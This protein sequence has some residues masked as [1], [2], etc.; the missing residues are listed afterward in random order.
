MAELLHGLIPLMKELGIPHDWKI[1]PLD[2]N[3]NLLAAHLVDL[4]QGIEHS[5]IPEADQHV[6]LE[7]LRRTPEMQQA[8]Q[9]RL[10]SISSMTFNSLPWLPY[11]PG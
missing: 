1:V 2:Q 9:I 4:L 7:K 11:F 10:I 5:D 3:S 8:K 6:F